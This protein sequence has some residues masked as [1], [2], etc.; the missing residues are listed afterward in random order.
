[1][2]V[3]PVV[4]GDAPLDPDTAALVAAAREAMVNAAKHAGVDEIDVYAEVEPETVEISCATAA[5]GSTR[6][7]CPTTGAASPA[8]SRDRMARHGGQVRLRTT[9]GE[10]TEVGLAAPCRRAR[11]ARPLRAPSE[12]TR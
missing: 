12:E 8:R 6:T 4:V 7:R 3:A 5:A 1:M 2:R 11:R 9:P 10:G